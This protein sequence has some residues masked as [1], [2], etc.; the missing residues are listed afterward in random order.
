MPKK[1]NWKQTRVVAHAPR[2]G[3]R[4]ELRYWGPLSAEEAEHHDATGYLPDERCIYP[5][6]KVRHTTVKGKSRQVGVART[7]AEAK[8]IAEADAD[9]FDGL[10]T[11]IAERLMKSGGDHAE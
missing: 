5:H 6:W 8:A 10:F 4:Y 3:G 9:P 7:L 2:V 11:E 1:L